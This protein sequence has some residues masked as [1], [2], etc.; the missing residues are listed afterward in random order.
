MFM[1]L[2]P[3]INKEWIPTVGKALTHG[4]TLMSD[5]SKSEEEHWSETQ[6]RHRRGIKKAMKMDVVTKTEFL[7][8]QNA[9][10]FSDIYK[11]TMR[12]VKASNYYFFDDDYFF[13]LLENLQE[14]NTVD[15]CLSR[16]QTNWVFYIYALSRVWH[17][18][19][20]SWRHAE[21]LY[22]PTTF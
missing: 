14:K 17:Y 7:T 8:R 11:E 9:M 5:L 1:R 22:A 13:N 19:V 21:R 10:V 4:L 6:N 20:P 12:H 3:I 15:N 18:A 2:H 16:R